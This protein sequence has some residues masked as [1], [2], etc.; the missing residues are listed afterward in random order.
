MIVMRAIGKIIRL[1]ELENFQE[2]QVIFIM[3]NGNKIK[4]MDKEYVYSKMVINMME[5]G[6]KI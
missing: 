1:M 4:F 2:K 6:M 3:E 5:N